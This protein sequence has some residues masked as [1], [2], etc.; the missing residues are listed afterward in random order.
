MNNTKS[1]D[2]GKIEKEVNDIWQQAVVHYTFDE[3]E[4]ITIDYAN[5]EH[6]VHG[7][8]TF[9]MPHEKGKTSAP[10][11]ISINVKVVRTPIIRIEP[12]DR[13]NFYLKF[14]YDD[15]LVKENQLNGDYKTTTI[16]GQT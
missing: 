5:K 9:G 15:A 7:K 10:E 13:E 4:P 8:F 11:S 6:F 16:G 1:L 14:G 12:V 3:L 2:L